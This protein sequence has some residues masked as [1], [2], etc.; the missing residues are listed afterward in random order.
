M[1]VMTIEIWFHQRANILYTGLSTMED[2]DNAVK[3]FKDNGCPF[4]L[5][6]CVST[7]PMDVEDANLNV[8]NTLKSRYG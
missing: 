3:I 1:I 4:E 6:H 2:I 8:I 7:Y 5:M